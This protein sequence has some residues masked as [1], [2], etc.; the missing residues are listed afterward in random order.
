M[1]SFLLLF[2]CL[3]M[4]SYKG[5]SFLVIFFVCVS[6]CWFF[7]CFCFGFVYK[8]F[9]ILN[10]VRPNSTLQYNILACSLIFLYFFIVWVMLSF[11]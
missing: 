9:Y 11:C 2:S 1:W 8:L 3:F 5:T 10:N 7:E 4:F 6:C